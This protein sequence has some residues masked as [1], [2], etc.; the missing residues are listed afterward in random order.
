MSKMLGFDRQIKKEWLDVT[1]ELLF[2]GKNAQHIREMQERFMALDLPGKDA[3]RKTRLVIS[4]MW[5]DNNTK[6]IPLRKRALEI[7]KENP[8]IDTRVFHWGMSIATYPFF[9]DIATIIG[10][11]IALQGNFKVSQVHDRIGKIWGGRST[12]T[13]ACSRVIQTMIMWEIIESTKESKSYNAVQK[14]RVAV[15][16]KQ[17]AQWLIYSLLLSR[18]NGSVPVEEIGRSPEL[19]PFSIEIGVDA[20]LFSNG[21]KLSHRGIKTDFISLKENNT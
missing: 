14:L 18:E 15:R 12:L 8:E 5:L 4:R 1:I 11:L 6:L 10:K 16:R 19:F 21:I 17:V 9:R 2:E 20:L 3:R 13:R 7:L